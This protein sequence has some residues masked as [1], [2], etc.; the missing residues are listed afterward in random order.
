MKVSDARVLQRSRVFKLAWLVLV[1]TALISLAACGGNEAANDPPP[2]TRLEATSVTV[3]AN[4]LVA[5]YSVSASGPAMV[6]VQFGPTASYGFQTSAQA[7]P[8][9]GGTVNVLVA[10]M[11]Q[12]TLYHMQA[13]LTT[14]SGQIVDQDQTFQTGAI[15]PNMMPPMQITVPPG[16]QPT[17]GIQ[18]I[19]S[20]G[21]ALAINPA[22]DII[23]FYQ[24]NTDDANLVKLLPDGHMLMWFELPPPHNWGLREVDLAGNVVRE[25]DLDELEQ[26]LQSAGYNM[27]LVS[28]DHDMLLMPNGHLVFIVSNTRVFTDLPGFPGQTT[29]QGN[30]II[31]VDQENN[32]SWV[33]DA[34]DHLDVNRHPMNFPD[35]TH[36]NSLF[37]VPDDGSLL[38][39]LRHQHWVLK[40]DYGSGRGAGDIV[41][42]LGNEGDFTL[43]DSTSPADWFYAQHDANIVST[44]LTGDIRLALFDDGD[45][46]VLDY[47]GDV[48]NMSGP[49]MC[50]STIPFFDVNEND[51]T[52]RREWSYQIAYSYWGGSNQLLSNSNVF[53]AESAPADLGTH[54]GRITEVTQTA[55]PVTVWQLVFTNTTVYRAKHLGSL[56]PG[57]QW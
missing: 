29:V 34:F 24:T 12:N 35:W 4:P 16:Q 22:G 40:I 42:K 56:Y 43:L 47:N 1:S 9:G 45:Y 46:R 15:P 49:P 18:L 23:W 7:I 13:V 36:A 6:S 57:V 53:Y 31:D 17:P 5:Q 28:I 52:A 11:K 33:W 21:E 26:K 51:R 25:L 20:T 30:A 14:D 2:V 41:W 39:S 8:E 10:G 55:N 44:N 54:V 48:C 37:Y 3:S 32:V 19:S 38:L 27:Q 50:Y